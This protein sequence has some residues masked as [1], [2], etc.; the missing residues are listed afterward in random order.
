VVVVVVVQVVVVVNFIFFGY[1]R[2]SSVT[3]MLI[4]LGL[5]S[6]SLELFSL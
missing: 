4:E 5:P 2:F 1:S 6:F 3:A